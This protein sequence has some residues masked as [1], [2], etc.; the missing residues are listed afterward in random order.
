[1]TV[2]LVASYYLVGMYLRQREF[3]RVELGSMAVRGNLL[4]LA[5]SITIAYLQRDVASAFPTAV[6][7]LAIG[8]HSLLS[9]G[10]RA[11]LE[12]VRK[13]Y[14]DA[15]HRVRRAILVG[16]TPEGR[17]LL[18][19]ATDESRFEYAFA[20]VV[21]DRKSREDA[22]SGFPVLGRTGE[23]GRVVQEEDVEEVVLADPNLPPPDLLHYLVQCAGLDVRFKVV[24]TLLELVR[25]RGRVK[26]V[27]G[28]PLVDLFGEEIP[29]VREMVKRISDI[30][31]ASLV[32]LVTLPLWPLIALAVKVSSRGPV[33]YRQE[34][35]GLHGRSFHV[36]KFRTMRS[37]A[38]VS[39]GPVLASADD[40]RVTP[41]G[42]FL[43][44]T[45]L[46]ELPQLL[47]ILVGEMSFVGPRPERPHFVRQF[48]TTVP[49]YAQRYRLRPGL[50]GLAQVEGAYE[51]AAR[52]KARYDLIYLNSR[53]L[54]LD[55][56]ILAK[57]VWVVLRG[58]GAR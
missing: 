28:V 31:F 19:A 50:T 48:L 54:M 34:R 56:K 13:Y 5:G 25:G 14:I 16:L 38:E 37:D 23:L 43:R 40:R 52:N 46:D 57:T 33:F 29:T 9:F 12:E 55:L 8:F 2:A 35:V 45:R 7:F 44:R 27:A 10:L 30:V 20:G 58:H 32:L 18:E 47:N 11:G 36:L 49:E 41:V 24:P 26:L 51:T 4:W 1:M 22:V 17:R 53:S 3:S 39:T 15:A 21:D 6:F 42:R